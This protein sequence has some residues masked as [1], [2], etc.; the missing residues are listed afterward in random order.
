MIINY[1]VDRIVGIVFFLAIVTMVGLY[2]FPETTLNTVSLAAAGIKPVLN[3][4]GALF[5]I[6]IEII[7]AILGVFN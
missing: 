5:D 3:I 7:K 6:F 2:F 4:F 1:Y